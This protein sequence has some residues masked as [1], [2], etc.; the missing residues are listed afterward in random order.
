MQ[1]DTV[2]S[3]RGFTTVT[4]AFTLFL[5]AG[6]A[7]T[8]LYGVYAERWHFGA[9]LL[10]VVFAVYAVALL[11]ALLL[12]G[13]L[14][15]AVGRKP[16]L[17]AATG[18]LVLSLL[19]FVAADGI[20]LLLV[21]RVVQ[22]FAT[23]LMTAAASAT[24]LDF[25]PAKRPGLAALANVVTAMGGQ[26][27]GILAAGALV[28]Y[29][30]QPTRLVY[31]LLSLLGIGCAVAIYVRVPE[32]RASRSSFAFNV[33]VSVPRDIR[34]AFLV[35]LPCLIATWALSS[36]YLSLGPDLV[37]ALDHSSNRLVSV[38]ASALL[39]GSGSASAF[40]ARRRAPRTRMLSGCA[41]LAAGSG[42][43]VAALAEQNTP[44]FYLSI[45]VAGL[46]FGTAFSGAFETLISLAGSG[47]RGALTAAVYVVAYVSFSV[48]AVIAG[49]V[50]TGAGLI[51][52]AEVYS[53]VIAVLAA[54]AFVATRRTTGA[55]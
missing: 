33:R 17:L 24:M 1:Q 47:D 8:P 36:L 32:P 35:A 21:A 10:T 42:L 53:T 46:G 29:G 30:P 50:T 3:R 12:F 49:V 37:L 25:E 2:V 31:V 38:S 44:I 7:P 14:S 16:V 27:L 45:L 55:R 5:C 26:T 43:T 11:G 18:L 51:P 4:G 41:A 9:G 40:A 20:I 52:T 15:D 23:G 54:V 39:L 13:N 6:G 34:P 22:G 28:Q 19:I 48:P